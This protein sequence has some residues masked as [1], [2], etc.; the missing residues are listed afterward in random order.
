MVAEPRRTILI[1]ATFQPIHALNIAMF[2]S[3]DSSEAR[4]LAAS[5]Y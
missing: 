3:R 2:A 4:Q 1:A 5:I